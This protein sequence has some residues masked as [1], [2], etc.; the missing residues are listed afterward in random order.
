MTQIQAPR[1]ARSIMANLLAVPIATALFV[2]AAQAE[3]IIRNGNFGIILGGESSRVYPRRDRAQPQ[4]PIPIA[5]LKRGIT[6]VA[7]A[8]SI[9]P[10]QSFT[11]EAVSIAPPQSF[12]V[13]QK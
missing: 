6:A 9:A 3:V 13:N 12:T 2:P 11:I 10:P 5:K 1:C 7:L 8:A 4:Q